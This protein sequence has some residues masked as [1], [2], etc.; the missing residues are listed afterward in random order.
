MS[1]RESGTSTNSYKGMLKPGHKVILVGL[2]KSCQVALHWPLW[3]TEFKCIGTIR[4][5]RRGIVVKDMF[6]LVRW[7][8]GAQVHVNEK[9]LAPYYGI[10]TGSASTDRKI[11]PNR[12]FFEVKERKRWM[13]RKKGHHVT[14]GKRKE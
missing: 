11:N 13:D 12:A 6:A 3:G 1:Y 2:P 7:D 8:N 4:E 9:Y 14:V 5:M 10:T